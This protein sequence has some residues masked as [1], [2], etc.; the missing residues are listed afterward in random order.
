MLDFMKSCINQKKRPN[1]SSMKLLSRN[2]WMLL[3]TLLRRST[4]M[5]LR[6]LNLIL[7]Q[8]SNKKL[9]RSIHL[10]CMQKHQKSLHNTTRKSIHKSNTKKPPRSIKSSFP[11][12]LCTL[13]QPKIKT[14]MNNQLTFTL[15]TD[16]PNL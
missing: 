16:N 12:T 14:M 1:K 4:R 10:F 6:M 5:L 7:K 13:N 15:P 2:M 9:Q 8:L 3:R 11:D